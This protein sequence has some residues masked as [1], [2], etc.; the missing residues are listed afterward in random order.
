MKRGFLAWVIFA[1]SLGAATQ[2]PAVWRNWEFAAPLQTSPTD[3]P[4][5]VA[6]VVPATVSAHAQSGW[7]DLRVIDSQERE[8][9]YLL[10]ARL[11]RKTIEWRNARLLEVSFIPG[12][13]SQGIVDTG[14]DAGIHNSVEIQTEEKDYFVWVEV[15][16]SDDSR[17]WRILNERSPIYRFAQ[18]GLGGNQ[19]I[20][21]SPSN[22]RYLRLRVLD[23]TKKFPLQGCRVAQEVFEEPERVALDAHFAADATAPPK[24]SWWG[25]D[26]VTA[27]RPISEVRFEVAQHEFHRPVRVEASDDNKLWRDIAYGDIYRSMAATQQRERLSITFPE[28]RSRYWRVEIFNRDDAPLT[29]VKLQLQATP[30]RVAFRQEAGLQYR[31]LYGNPRAAAP[32][33]EMARLTDPKAIAAAASIALGAEQV[34]IAFADPAPWTERHGYLLW[35]AV[36]LAVLVLGKLA[37]KSLRSPA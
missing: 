16:I 25:A 29:D 2:L 5:F 18:D 37:I 36:V 12:Q 26:L 33:Y 21:Y 34:N 11:E 15:A 14:I 19:F 27:T 8:V 1:A 4:R 32:E 28:D 31:L 30:R 20:R 10:E 9:P 13:D 24:Q 23:G 3:D 7:N 17:T 22:S 35:A 6:A